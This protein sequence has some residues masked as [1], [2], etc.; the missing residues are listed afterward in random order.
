MKP[1]PPSP[2]NSTF[3]QEPDS[4]EHSPV[5]Q[6]T[7]VSKT[8]CRNLRRSLWYGIKDIFRE[9]SFQGSYA[10]ELRDQEFEAVKNASFEV[11][12]GE[13]VALLGPN[14]AGKSSMLKMMNGILRPNNG[15]IQ[16]RGR[17]SALIE[18]G[19]GFNPVLSGRENVFINASILGFSREETEAKFDEILEFSEIG[20]FIDSPVQSY[21]SGMKVRLGFAVASHLA[22]DLLLVDEVLAVGDLA[23][24]LKCYDHL[25]QRVKSG[26]SVIL[27]SHIVAMM[28][29][30]CTRAIVFDKGEIVFD[31]DIMAGIAEYQKILGIEKAKLKALNENDFSDPANP[32]DDSLPIPGQPGPAPEVQIQS[33]KT[34]TEDLEETATFRS[35]D[36]IIVDVTLESKI[37]LRECKLVV[38][39]D[40][41][42]F[43]LVATMASARQQFQFDINQNTNGGKAT[44]RLFLK[45]VPLIDGAYSFN[46][47]L[48]GEGKQNLLDQKNAL[49]SFSILNPNE[50]RRVLKGVLLLNHS[51]EIGAAP[52]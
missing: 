17:V 12:P 13:C 18:L 7:N 9:L 20:E 42:A 52:F 22:P 28:P 19:T 11:S 39:L 40:S 47:T 4:S 43:G 46:V 6:V 25:Q 51:W 16:I 31:G 8:Y 32:T 33:V 41:S 38:N 29:R 14:G 45:R 26:M 5:V 23:F 35:G 44:V 37:D 30:F 24:R 3:H 15:K 27:V 48:Y 2:S 1:T 50:K 10:G 34:Y 36:A 49:G 21:S